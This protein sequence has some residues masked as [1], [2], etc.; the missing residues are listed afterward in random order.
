MLK[1]DSV[2][3]QTSL[4]K[5]RMLR[6]DGAPLKNSEY[7][8]LLDMCAEEG[9][10]DNDIPRLELRTEIQYDNLELERDV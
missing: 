6:M 7:M 3:S 10:V 9:E 5:T 8:H 4:V 1:A 2:F